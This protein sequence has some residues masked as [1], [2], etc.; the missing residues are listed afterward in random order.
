MGRGFAAASGA[1][2]P[3]YISIWPPSSITRFGGMRKNSVA[4]SAL[5]CMK[6]NTPRLNE[7]K[8]ER[9]APMIETRPTKNDVSIMLNTILCPAI[10]ERPGN[11]RLFHKAV[12]DGDGMTITA[13]IDDLNSIFRWHAR[14]ISGHDA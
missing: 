5:R 6:S 2:K 3:G 11:V 1:A 12:V 4:G 7:L 8:R 9:L 14:D 13:E 10:V